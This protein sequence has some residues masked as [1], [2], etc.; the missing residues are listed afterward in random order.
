M[1][2]GEV[3]NG[4]VF[5]VAPCLVVTASV[6]CSRDAPM[7]LRWSLAREEFA[8]VAD[9]ARSLPEG[10]PTADLSGQLGTYAID[11]VQVAGDAGFAYVPEGS[12][13]SVGRLFESIHLRPLGD[14]WYAF[15]ASW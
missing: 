15:T 8:E 2:I 14:D 4:L 1:T 3:G 7:Q 11:D 13:R 5:L 9:A 6:L 12:R 10:D